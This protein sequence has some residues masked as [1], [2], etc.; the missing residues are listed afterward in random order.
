[1]SVCRY[2]CFSRDPWLYLVVMT[3]GLGQRGG[4]MRGNF[5]QVIATETFLLQ[6]VRRAGAEEK[7]ATVLGNQ[8]GFLCIWLLHAAFREPWLSDTAMHRMADSMVDEDDGT[9][10]HSNACSNPHTCVGNFDRKLRE[11]GIR[12]LL[13][14]ST[15]SRYTAASD[16]AQLPRYLVQRAQQCFLPTATTW[17]HFA[18]HPASC[19]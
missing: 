5:K 14:M 10:Q 11:D 4:G 17:H 15:C 9:R 12:P 3:S 8:S 1:V 18:A 19:L 6:D 2:K 13:S 7:H 16:L